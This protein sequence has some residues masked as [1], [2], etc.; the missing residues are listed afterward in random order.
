M[1]TLN[2]GK[3]DFPANPASEADALAEADKRPQPQPFPK[4]TNL[5]PGERFFILNGEPLF[6][7]FAFQNDIG[8]PS[9]DAKYEQA[10][11][12]TKEDLNLQY[13]TY[14]FQ[15]LLLRNEISKDEQRHFINPNQH[16]SLDN[17]Q[18]LQ[19][20]Q[21]PESE[22]Q[23]DQ[24]KDSQQNIQIPQQQIP[25]QNFQIPNEF[26]L[27]AIPFNFQMHL[28]NQFATVQTGTQQPASD[29]SANP[30]GQ[31]TLPHF[32]Q[33]LPQ[34]QQILTESRTFPQNAFFRSGL[35]FG[36]DGGD[37]GF[38]G[39]GQFRYSPPSEPYYPS[40]GENVEN[41][42]IVVNANFEDASSDSETDKVEDESKC[43]ISVKFL[44]Y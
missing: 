22:A 10:F 43:F 36:F 34:D 2:E 14:P 18:T 30:Q 17:Q 19:K 35:P 37:Q 1:E 28:P 44:T 27:Q 13:N 41:D 16:S 4:P 25:E 21:V 6:Q 26:K 23:N 31:Q 33:F 8:L 38:D 29:Q 3:V 20:N 39:F 32:P 24:Q 40:D 12:P 5:K 9:L 11:F 7:N 15:A 42:S